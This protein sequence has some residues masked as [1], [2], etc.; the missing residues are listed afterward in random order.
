MHLWH[1]RYVF[2]TR[3]S[4]PQASANLRL[5]RQNITSAAPG[6]MPAM[7]AA[8]KPSLQGLLRPQSAS[9]GSLP[10]RA[11]AVHTASGSRANAHTSVL[12]AFFKTVPLA[13][14]RPSV[15]LGRPA[16]TVSDVLSA[17]QWSRGLEVSVTDSYSP[18]KR[19]TIR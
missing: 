12:P 16:P 14:L 17:G 7:S 3:L 10:T 11:A 6:A 9:G 8:L 19:V 15:G 5:Y 13:A 18:I 4:Q 1:F 2:A